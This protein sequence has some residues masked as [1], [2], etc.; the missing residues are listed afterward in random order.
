MSLILN[1][2]PSLR[3]SGKIK[4]GGKGAVRKSKQGVEFQAPEK[5]DHFIITTM[6][7]DAD[8]NFLPDAALMQEVAKATGQEA[9]H[10]TRIPV[11]L[12]FDDLELNFQGSYAAYLGKTVWCRGNGVE[13]QRIGAEGSYS[14]CACPCERIER[15]FKATKTDPKCKIN[16]SLSV[17]IDGAA[18]LGGTWKFRTTSFNSHDAL[19]GSLMF[20]HR[21]AGGRIA[22]I[23][24][25][26]VVTPKKVAD[27][28][29]RQQTIY[30]VGLEFRG[31]MEGLRQAALEH[32]TQQAQAGFQIAQIEEQTRKL[33]TSSSAGVFPDDDVEGVAA[34]FYPDAQSHTPAPG[35]PPVRAQQRPF[36]SKS[37]LPEGTGEL[38][39]AKLD[40]YITDM[41]AAF[42]KGKG[43]EWWKAHAKQLKARC[44]P[45]QWERLEGKKDALKERAPAP[46]APA[47]D[48]G[49]LA[50]DGAPSPDPA[51]Q[52]ETD[53]AV[54]E[55]LAEYQAAAPK[56][57]NE[58]R[59]KVKIKTIKFTKKQ[60][61]AVQ[62][63]VDMINKLLDAAEPE[64]F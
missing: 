6:E 20:I 32:A 19:F 30:V 25:E 51:V 55:V 48:A 44:T 39:P 35:Q 49:Q 3:E 9:D 57:R 63:G 8:D 34:E 54:Q 16:A 24:L 56:D 26:L 64:P 31:T 46:E 4:I 50:T 33:L 47:E 14:T 12:L 1:R 7:K 29:G 59:E 52:D 22:G 38:L 11:R 10:L 53:P 58:A 40:E 2:P 42:D 45:E 28:D 23:P 62:E 36:P 17:L 27:P 41:T 60:R 15:D 43:P 18:G 13:A 61:D 37:D 21:A 5:Y